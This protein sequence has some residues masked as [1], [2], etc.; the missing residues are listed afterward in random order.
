MA[1]KMTWSLLFTCIEQMRKTKR[2]QRNDTLHLCSTFGLTPAELELF[3][4]GIRCN[5]TW[6]QA[7]RRGT[8]FGEMLAN[9]KIKKLYKSLFALEQPTNITFVGSKAALEGALG[10]SSA[11]MAWDGSTTLKR[12]R[13]NKVMNWGTND[14]KLDSAV[15]PQDPVILVPDQDISK[16][17]VHFNSSKLLKECQRLLDLVRT[18]TGINH[19]PVIMGILRFA[20]CLTSFGAEAECLT[21]TPEVKCS[22]F[23]V[24]RS[25]LLHAGGRTGR[26]KRDPLKAAAST[27][28]TS[29]AP[30]V[31]WQDLF[32]V[33][34]EHGTRISA[35]SS[36][37]S[38]ALTGK[39]LGLT[40]KQ[41]DLLADGIASNCVWLEHAA[42]DIRLSK[43]CSD[44]KLLQIQ[45][46]L[47][48]V[49]AALD[50]HFLTTDTKIMQSSKTHVDHGGMDWDLESVTVTR[51]RKNKVMN[52]G[53]LHT[54]FRPGRSY[55]DRWV[56]LEPVHDITD[57]LVF[58]TG[59]VLVSYARKYLTL[60]KHLKKLY[61]PFWVELGVLCEA[62]IQMH[63]EFEAISYGER[64]P[65]KVSYID[66]DEL[67]DN[68][69]RAAHSPRHPVND[70]PETTTIPLRKRGGK[71]LPV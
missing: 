20:E 23:A 50:I 17:I 47:F 35:V 39:L 31:T 66:E 46:D 64:V 5:M 62:I 57:N 29:A 51:K 3:V 4:S 54:S 59:P 68:D 67:I 36:P 38:L 53:T 34:K 9:A 14:T 55:A 16:Y 42:R 71:P 11:G 25:Q 8:H 56:V 32:Y 63:S 24:T 27:E 70:P 48:V 43:A 15:L 12:K 6:F 69:D 21:F 19:I 40:A 52:W 60:L 1:S 18:D 10:E 58:L 2:D 61:A 26:A 33:L 7:Q 41:V 45:K 37:E 65:C 30:H 22:V 28:A 49:D 44:P 13:K